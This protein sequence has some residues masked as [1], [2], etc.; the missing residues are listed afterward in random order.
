[1][2]GK[3][4]TV[5]E[6]KHL[7]QMVEAHRSVRAIARALGKTRES[8]RVKIARLGLVV[9]DRAENQSRTTTTCA[10]LVLPPELP[11]VEEV[12]KVLVAAMEALKNPG[13]DKTE[14]LRLRSL[15]QAA[16]AYQAKVSEFID[17]RGIE[18]KLGEMEEKYE[19][20]LGEKAKHVDPDD[21][22]AAVSA[23]KPC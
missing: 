1:M 10:E 14:I 5:E 23:A 20:L 16:T 12:L 7:K 18:A 3:P 22:K 15:I 2:R 6:E 9:V 11:S 19:R 21:G 13:L 4:W 8:V 17:Y